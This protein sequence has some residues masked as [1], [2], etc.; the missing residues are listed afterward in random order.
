MDHALNALLTV[1]SLIAVLGPVIIVHEF[2]HFLAGR[3]LG[4]KIDA[5]S[6][7]WGSILWRKRDKSG[8][9]WRLS[10]LPIGGYVKFAGDANPASTHAAE[11]Y[12]DPIEKARARREGYFHAQPIWKRA[13]V[14]AAGPFTNFIFAIVTFALLLIVFGRAVQP[15]IIGEVVAGKAAAEAGLQPGDRIV[16]IAGKPVTDFSDVVTLVASAPGQTEVFVVERD[17]RLVTTRV[18]PRPTVRQGQYIGEIGVGTVAGAG[19]VERVGPLSAVAIAGQQTAQQIDLTLNYLGRLVT[20]RAKPDQVSGVIGIAA[21]T[22]HASERAVSGDGSFF[23]KAIR[24]LAVWVLFAPNISVAI[25]IANL[26]PI[27]V[28]DGGQLVGFLI[29]ALRRG[30]PLSARVTEIGTYAGFAAIMAIFLFA[31]WND[32]QHQKIFQFL[33]G[34]MSSG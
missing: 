22:G 14:V 4:V 8:V 2:G 11:G 9:E 5:F 10:A 16:S 15:P 25:G 17:H 33:S 21:M 6:I 1:I 13:I 19:K 29:E 20:G 12:D 24:L 32:L 28:L 31:G 26:L 23:A 34:V 27:P 7:G 30:R 3:W 18:T